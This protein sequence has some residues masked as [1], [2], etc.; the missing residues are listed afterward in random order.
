MASMDLVAKIF[1][2]YRLDG[3]LNH[4]VWR[5]ASRTATG[6]GRGCSIPGTPLHGRSCLASHARL[7]F[8][9]VASATVLWYVVCAVGLS[10]PRDFP[11]PRTLTTPRAALSREWP[12]DAT[13]SLVETHM[14]M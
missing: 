1:C 4:S 13:T 7:F 9:S 3:K 8:R 12:S 6:V 11:I 5:E 14:Y 2:A 10:A